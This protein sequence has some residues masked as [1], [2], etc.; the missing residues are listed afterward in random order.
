MFRYLGLCGFVFAGLASA[1]A[2]QPSQPGPSIFADSSLQAVLDPIVS[3][4]TARF[5]RSPVVTYGPS[6]GL[7]Q[8]I[9]A[10]AKPDLFFA[11]DPQVMDGLIK[12]GLIDGHTRNDFVTSELVL[13]A[14]AESKS[15]LKMFTGFDLA[16][17]LGAGKLAICED[18]TCLAGSYARQALR[19]FKVW[20]KV[21]PDLAQVPDDKA[22]VA[23][24][25][26]GA[27]PLG[28]VYAIDAK[29]EPRVRA[30]D[31]FPASSHALIGFPIALVKG[32]KNPDGARFEAFTRSA[33]ATKVFLAQGFTV[34]K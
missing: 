34:L 25:A 15:T 27:A 1:A 7:A 4:W 14:P 16:G 31:V 32:G 8:R 13:I 24:V 29:A 28:V 9:E 22:A 17:A 12:D 10:G 21:E 11:A 23:L 18:V 20:A 6:A 2:A 19:F 33:E 30:V 5:G 26:S 3:A